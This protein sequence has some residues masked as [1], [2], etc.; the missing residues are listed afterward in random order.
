MSDDRQVRELEATVEGLGQQN[1]ELER[2]ADAQAETLQ[3]LAEVI[4]KMVDAVEALK[5]VPVRDLV[6][7]IECIIDG[8]AEDLE[9]TDS[10]RE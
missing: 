9:P 7:S 5:E 6:A 4:S 8:V 1:A 3:W 10:E 2:L